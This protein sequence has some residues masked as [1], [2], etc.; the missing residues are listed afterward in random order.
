ME[1][2]SISLQTICAGGVPEVFE[3]ELKAVLTNI[4]DP[5]TSAEKARSITMKFVFKPTEDRSGATVDFTCRA[6]LQP[7]K[8][9]K[10]QMYLSRHTGPLKAYSVDQRQVAMFGPEAEA[11]ASITAVK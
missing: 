5:N 6:A 11:K 1:P 2:E 7:V 9:V 3:H 8:V 10:S 4:T